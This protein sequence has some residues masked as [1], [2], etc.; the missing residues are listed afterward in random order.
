M[1]YN[2]YSLL[3][4]KSK[5]LWIDMHG[6]V[7]LHVVN[8]PLRQFGMLFLKVFHELIWQIDSLPFAQLVTI[9]QHLRLVIDM[10]PRIISPVF[11]ILLLICLIL[12]FMLLNPCFLHLVVLFSFFD[13]FIKLLHGL[14]SWFVS[15]TET[16][17]CLT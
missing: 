9:V 1:K 4:S 3:F 8:A 5:I 17:F 11:F 2:F 7:L 12:S 15:L 14:L 13:K 16:F 6:A 10:L